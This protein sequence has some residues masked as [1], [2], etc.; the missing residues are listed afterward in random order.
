M[1][2]AKEFPTCA[3]A[4]VLTDICLVEKGFN[5]AFAAEIRQWIYGDQIWTHEIFGEEVP[6]KVKEAGYGQF[7][8]MPTRAEAL[9]DYKAATAKALAAYGPTVTVARGSNR[10]DKHPMDTLREIMPTVPVAEVIKNG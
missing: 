10:R 7:P 4:S 5:S 3:V 8:D 6:A 1:P 9:A 2:E